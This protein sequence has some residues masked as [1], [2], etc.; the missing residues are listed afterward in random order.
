MMSSMNNTLDALKQRFSVLHVEF[1][2]A[3]QTAIDIETKDLHEVLAYLKTA[4]F[5]QLSL[6]TCVDL[7][8]EDV[9]QMIFILFDWEEGQRV[10]V[11]CR[12]DR[13]NPK[14]TTITPIYPG[15][16]YYER[17]VH[18]FFGVE[19]TGNEMSG[20]MLFLENWDDMPPM[21]KD[22]D[23]LEYSKRKFPDREQVNK[24]QGEVIE[25]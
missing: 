25:S 10:V 14:L 2:M 12:I 3:N 17:D 15:A 8:K 5:R 18:E 7:I 20:K 23:P 11:R 4:G 16:Q 6:L 9:F 13:K 1:P 24:F 22:F 21:R 19:F